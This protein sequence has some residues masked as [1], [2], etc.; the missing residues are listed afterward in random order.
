M[1]ILTRQRTLRNEPR[2]D[3]SH[4]GAHRSL[5][6]SLILLAIGMAAVAVLGPL[7][8][9]VIEYHVSAGA[10]NQIRGGDIAVLVLAVPASLA[11]GLLLRRGRAA[12]LVLALGPSIYALYMYSQLALGGDI[13]R[14]P[15]NSERFFLLYLAIFILSGWIAVE[16]WRVISDT[17]LPP[18]PE[19]P[20]KAFGWFALVVVFFL[21]VGLHL[22]GLADAWS[23]RPVGPEYLADPVVFWLVK[24]MDLGL[25]VPVVTAVAVG[26]LRNSTWATK[27]ACAVSVWIALLG[28]SVAGMAIVMQATDDPAASVANTI[29]FGSFAVIAITIAVALLVP[30]LT[31]LDEPRTQARRIAATSR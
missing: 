29:V 13:S 10:T 11:A 12:G 20:G 21:A 14:Y 30:V 4:V 24:F 17:V 8:A 6:A 2:I 7:V 9:G 1:S 5:A 25:V 28:S 18:I 3:P 19:R 15:G 27:A 31:M 23:S 16:A 22:P 26:T